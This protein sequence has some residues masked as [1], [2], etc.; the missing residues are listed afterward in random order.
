VHLV[1]FITGIYYDAWSYKHQIYHLKFEIS[2]YIL[3]KQ[4]RC[5]MKWA[6]LLQNHHVINVTCVWS[7]T[8]AV[9]ELSYLIINF[10]I[11]TNTTLIKKKQIF[12]W[13]TDKKLHNENEIYVYRR[14]TFWVWCNF[15]VDDT[16]S[17]HR[18]TFIT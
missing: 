14:H 5:Y 6:K 11:N 9:S 17:Y 3:H 12:I 10:P 18:L 7:W 15:E 16:V 13:T 8:I 1:G 2:L 4:A